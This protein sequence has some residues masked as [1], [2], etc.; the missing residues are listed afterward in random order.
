VALTQQEMTRF[1]LSARKLAA[2]RLGRSVRVSHYGEQGVIARQVAALPPELRVCVDIGASDGVSGSNTLPLF[3]AG[4]AGLAV[5]MD[6]LAFGLLAVV[7]ARHR[8]VAVSRLQ[9]TPENVVSLLCAHGIPREFGLLSLDIDGYD[10][11]VL[12]AVL[13]QYRPRLIVAEINEK[14]P[15]P[16][17]FT[18]NWSPHYR[19]LGD[20]FYGQSLSAVADLAERHGYVLT[21]VHYNNAFLTPVEHFEGAAPSVALAYRRGY[22]ERPDRLRRFPWNTRFEP[23]QRMAPEAAAAWL[24]DFFSARRGEYELSL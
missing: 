21:E 16:L 10:H 18:V 7:L 15:P 17:H 14:V 13:A 4:W 1:L 19:Y 24:D 6:G 2:M 22:A 5:E 8:G 20:H 12:D 11:F 9:V 23:L 3:R